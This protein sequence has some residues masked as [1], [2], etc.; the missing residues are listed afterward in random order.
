MLHG[1]GAIE[2]DPTEPIEP[3]GEPAGV[4][5]PV[6]IPNW[7]WEWARWYLHHGE[8]KAAEPRDPQLRP[9]EAPRHIPQWA[10]RR[11][12][13]IAGEKLR[14]APAEQ[15]SLGAEGEDVRRLE[16]TL[17]S[18]GFRTGPVDGRFSERTETAV[19]AFE[20]LHGLG[21]DTVVEPEE[22]RAALRARRPDPPLARPDSYLY[23]D[24]DRQVLYDVRDGR[25]EQV[26]P[27]STGGGYTYTG[28]DGLQH[29]AVTPSGRFQIFR[30]VA[31]WDL[32]YLGR[33]YYPVYFH[34]GYAIHGSKSVPLEP[35]SH[36]CVR[37]PIW[38]A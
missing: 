36:G 20:K 30:K 25:V 34:G 1:P 37:I 17:R 10:W 38:L 21:L 35:V 9:E 26:L 15:L 22:Y 8:F 27:V 29:V 2:P 7:F 19:A 4:Q 3:P 32:S 5:W 6:P 12:R 33:L 18:I 31:G 23:V 14:P 28:R 16:R 11:V 24:L 13:V